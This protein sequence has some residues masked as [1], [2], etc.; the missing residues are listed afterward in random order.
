M[1]RW[2]VW[3]QP[4]PLPGGIRSI[5]GLGDVCGAGQ[6]NG[7]M[8]KWLTELAPAEVAYRLV[9]SPDTATPSAMASVP[10]GA[11]AAHPG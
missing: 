9:P 2:S 11:V 10:A 1:P 8:V 4:A 6:N 7:A 3:V 5:A